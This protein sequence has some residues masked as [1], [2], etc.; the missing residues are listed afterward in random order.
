MDVNDRA[1]GFLRRM[2]NG[3][4]LASSVGQDGI[5]AAGKGPK[6]RIQD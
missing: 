5:T 6:T 1:T 4:L 2:G 3:K